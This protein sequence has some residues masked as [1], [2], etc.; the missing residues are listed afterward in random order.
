MLFG[1]HGCWW[2]LELVEA[3]GKCEVG[4]GGRDGLG[5]LGTV[6]VAEAGAAGGGVRWVASG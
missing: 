3:V 5:E 4:G 1:G 6:M 2:S